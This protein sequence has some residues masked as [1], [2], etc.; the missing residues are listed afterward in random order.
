M[1]PGHHDKVALIT[2]GACPALGR[3]TRRFVSAAFRGNNLADGTAFPGYA[4]YHS[5]AARR[6][7]STYSATWFASISDKRRILM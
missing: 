6:A 3:P 1:P 7:I 4:H 2:G 5:S